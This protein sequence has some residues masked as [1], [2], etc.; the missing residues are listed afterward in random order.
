MHSLQQV[1]ALLVYHAWRAPVGCNNSILESNC[2]DISECTHIPT[3]RTP[4]PPPGSWKES[5][6]RDPCHQICIFTQTNVILPL[7][8]FLVLWRQPF[9]HVGAYPCSY[10]FLRRSHIKYCCRSADWLFCVH[11]WMNILCHMTNKGRPT[12]PNCLFFNIVQTTLDPHP[13]VFD[14]HDANFLKDY[15]KSMLTFFAT[16]FNKIVHNSVGENFKFALNLWQFYPQYETI[17][18]SEGLFIKS[19]LRVHKCIFFIAKKPPKLWPN[20]K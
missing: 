15:W 4:H 7:Q 9:S 14:N 12:I 6:Y 19:P 1:K 2:V 5:P 10:T 13:L 18:P 8:S 3:W 20:T 16:A 11:C 17:L